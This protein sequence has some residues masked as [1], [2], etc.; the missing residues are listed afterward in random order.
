MKM[1]QTNKKNR[2]FSLIELVI[3]MAIAAILIGGVAIGIGIL[4]TANTRGLADR[5]NSS[6]SELKTKNAGGKDRQYLHIYR[7][8]KAYYVQFTNSNTL[9]VSDFDKGTR[10]GKG[11]CIVK[12]GGGAELANNGVY[13]FTVSKKDG[14]FGDKYY[15]D[16][17]EQV[18]TS[19][20]EIE[21]T[22]TNGDPKHSVYLVSNTGR[23]YVE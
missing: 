23:H 16:G 9:A 15:K 14:S 10:L 8:D 21:V 11:D 18:L 6:F 4:K 19:P 2:G 5:I 3:V 13:S 1:I 20:F 22:A 17:V 7:K 12:F